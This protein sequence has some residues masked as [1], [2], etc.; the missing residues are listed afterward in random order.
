MSDF[1][2]LSSHQTSLLSSLSEF[3]IEELDKIYEIAQEVDDIEFVNW[4][5]SFS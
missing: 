5:E 3:T 2:G 4:L 1:L